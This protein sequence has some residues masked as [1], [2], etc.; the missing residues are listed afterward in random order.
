MLTT[1]PDRNISPMTVRSERAF[2]LGEILVATTL[3]AVIMAAVL[4]SFLMMGRSGAN[5]GNYVAMEQQVRQAL[6]RF[7]QDVRMAKYFTR[8]SATQ[9]KLTIPQASD[10]GTDIVYYTYDSTAKTFTRLG[11]DP[12]TNVANTTTL[13]I[14]EVQSC[15]FK[16]WMLGSTGPAN[17]DAATDQ[18]QI[19][20]TVRKTALTAVAT[21]N[22]VV[23]ARF[24]LRNH[25]TNSV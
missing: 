5:A 23:S 9:I 21:T 11:P 25:R 12:I 20:L 4:S 19:R 13:L 2:T 22:L 1:A 10:S 18:V 15:E 7:G 3:S 8:V 16:R 14:K 6:E 17:S 24:V